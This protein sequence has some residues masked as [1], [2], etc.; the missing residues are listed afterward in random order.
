VA[1]FYHF[2]VWPIEVDHKNLKRDDNRISNLRDIGARKSLQ[3]ANKRVRKDN[4]IRVKGV[5]R[6]SNGRFVAKIC[7]RHLGTF[8]TAR[9]A[10]AVYVVEA[11]KAF[12]EFARA[13]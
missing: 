2:G 12:G 13:T 3:N 11:K 10:H 9:E 8:S 5:T 7:R 4:E 6:L 1:W